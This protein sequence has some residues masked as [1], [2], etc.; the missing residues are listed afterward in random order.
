MFVYSRTE[1]EKRCEGEGLSCYCLY[2]RLCNQISQWSEVEYRIRSS[3]S[4]ENGLGF[5]CGRAFSTGEDLMSDRPWVIR[6]S[7][8]LRTVTVRLPANSSKR[9]TGVLFDVFKYVSDFYGKQWILKY[10]I[11]VLS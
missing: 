1:E 5:V 11:Q 3:H 2:S 6:S 4:N 8:R 10:K 7:R 9:F